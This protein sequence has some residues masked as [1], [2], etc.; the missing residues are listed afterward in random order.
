MI[1][2]LREQI[3]KIDDSIAE[4]F[5]KRLSLCEKIGKI[6]AEK[7]TPTDCPDREA[8]IIERLSKGLSDAEKKEIEK[9][10]RK[11]F[12]ISKS[13]QKKIADS[14]QRQYKACLLGGNVGGSLSKKIHSYFGT[15]YDLISI[16]EEDLKEFFDDSDYDLVNVTMPYKRA[17]S[18]YLDGVDDV[19]KE[20]G[21]IN[22]VIIKNG[23]KWGY[24]TDIDGLR[25]VFNSKKVSVSGKN[26]VIAGTGGTA[27]TA[28]TLMKK[29][30]AKTVTL[31]SRKGEW[32]YENYH[33]LKDTEIFINATP[34]GSFDYSAPVDLEKFP[35]L[36][37]VMDV[38]Y[39][40][41]KTKLILQ[42]ERL[43]INHA[44]GLTMLVAQ[45]AYAEGLLQN[46]DFSKKISAL[47]RKTLNGVKNIVLI[48]MPSVGKTFI[49]KK[50]AEKLGMN[51][52]D[53]DEEVFKRYNKTA[54]EIILRGGE[55]YF[56][57]IENEVVKDIAFST[58]SVIATGGGTVINP[59]NVELLRMNGFLVYLTG[60][61]SRLTDENR[62][63]TKKYGYEK[64]YEKRSEIYLSASDIKIFND[65]AEGV[66]DRIKK[67][68]EKNLDN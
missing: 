33:L 23:K 36:N 27:Q 46:K 10:Y 67:E 9:L 48:G 66:A 37:F 1:D 15:E 34:L 19:A 32:N 16:K 17:V 22:T 61:L 30:G 42:A 53:T 41:L 60:D 20:I 6:K 54:E 29:L 3:D 4:K 24:N 58:S 40:P 43:K 55:E 63:L 44:G 50:L 57:K 49:G 52:I 7:G 14:K 28:K 35:R 2:K 39:K 25:Y 31:L 51:F 13:R 38:I 26:V 64:L 47:C 65:D 59:E 45:A 8:A 21:S 62:P 11:I 5:L 56:R 12:Q 18:D 68:Y